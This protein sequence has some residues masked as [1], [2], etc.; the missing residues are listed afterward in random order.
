VN[1][2]VAVIRERSVNRLDLE[3]A[4]EILVRKGAAG[5]VDWLAGWLASGSAENDRDSGEKQE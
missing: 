2:A 3:A 1:V 5:A 4:I